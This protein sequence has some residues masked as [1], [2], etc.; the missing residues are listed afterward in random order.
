MRMK[1][2]IPG[3]SERRTAQRIKT[4]IPCVLTFKSKEVTGRI[5]DISTT[6]VKMEVESFFPSEEIFKLHFY[7]DVHFFKYYCTLVSANDKVLTAMFM[8]KDVGS[9]NNLAY[10]L[11]LID[12]GEDMI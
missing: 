8:S 12:M 4:N 10:V 5:V 9:D 7:F 3:Y 1:D 11:N 6:G 2:F